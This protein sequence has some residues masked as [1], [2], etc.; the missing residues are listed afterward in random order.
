V[1]N[2]VIVTCIINRSANF[3]FQDLHPVSPDDNYKAHRR[4]ILSELFVIVIS[5]NH[6][7]TPLRNYNP[8]VRED[9]FV[10]FIE[11]MKN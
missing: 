11:L 10:Y 5:K 3:D 4:L 9:V 2:S 7:Y 1:F 6:Y 8:G